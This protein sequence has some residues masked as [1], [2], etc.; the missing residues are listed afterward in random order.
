MLKNYFTLIAIGLIWG[1][2][3]IFQETALEAFT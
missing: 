1:S 3:F 2:Q